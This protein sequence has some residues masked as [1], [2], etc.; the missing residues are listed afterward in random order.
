VTLARE[1][2]WAF[3][4][5]RR[6]V[7]AALVVRTGLFALTPA[8]IV[9]LLVAG[10]RHHRP[11]LRVPP[12][13][14]VVLLVG[15]SAWIA[16][17]ATGV[18]CARVA[19]ASPGRDAGEG[20]SE[21]LAVALVGGVYLLV[22]FGVL[23]WLRLA[24]AGA[25]TRYPLTGVV[26]PL[27]VATGCLLVL[28]VLVHLARSR[29][30]PVME[31]QATLR[32][33]GSAAVVAAVLAVAVVGLAGADRGDHPRLHVL[34]MGVRPGSLVAPL[35][36]TAVA[37]TIIRFDPRLADLDSCAD[38]VLDDGVDVVQ[39]P[40]IFLVVLGVALVPIIGVHHPVPA[41]ATVVALTVLIVRLTGRRVLPV[42][43]CGLAFVEYLLIAWPKGVFRHDAG[44]QAAAGALDRGGLFGSGPGQGLVEAYERGPVTLAGGPRTGTGMVADRYALNV[45]A[46][47]VGRIGVI[48]VLVTTVLIGLLVVRLA[49]RAGP[50]VRGAWA[51]GLAA[52]TVVTLA[53]PVVPLLWGDV[54]V[55]AALPG[56]APD[57]VSLVVLLG[58][59]AVLLGLAGGV[60]P[61]AETETWAAR[62]EARGSFPLGGAHDARAGRGAWGERRW[63]RFGPGLVAA[64]CVLL[65]LAAML[66]SPSAAAGAAPIAAADSQRA[67]M[68]GAPA[69][70]WPTL[71][72]VDPMV[73]Q[74]LDDQLRLRPRCGARLPRHAR[75]PGLGAAC[76]PVPAVTLDGQGQ[77]V[78]FRALQKSGYTGSVVA[79]DL[80]SGRLSVLAGDSSRTA[81][82]WSTAP[83]GILAKLLL[84]ATLNSDPTLAQAV[85]NDLRLAELTDHEPDLHAGD[86]GLVRRLRDS[87]QW[88]DPAF[89]SL[90]GK[91][92][93][94]IVKRYE[95]CVS[96]PG[97]RDDPPRFAT[98]GDCPL[99]VASAALA[100]RGR[101]NQPAATGKS[102]RPAVPRS[103]SALTALLTAKL[104]SAGAP[105]VAGRPV[106]GISAGDGEDCGG[107]DPCL[108]VSPLA[109]TSVVAALASLQDAGTPRALPAPR[110]LVDAGGPE[111]AS[112]AV[113]L[114]PPAFGTFG[115]KEA[116]PVADG[117]GGAWLIRLP[118]QGSGRQRT[119][120]VAHLQP[121][122]SPDDGGQRSDVNTAITRV[123]A[124]VADALRG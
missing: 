75:G 102:D 11:D 124:T 100:V 43:G 26:L 5:R 86:P 85:W 108:L 23:V 118:K 80:G 44:S 2:A 63:G 46:E 31:D 41:I 39:S 51:C 120:I 73:R 36:V 1:R 109:L 19:A 95:K 113:G 8:T 62:P 13:S 72:G 59:V 54:D 34:G 110:L 82:W 122:D 35:V 52:G 70:R 106:A 20:E 99:R 116:E 67:A 96:E 40:M 89:T 105:S 114:H 50:G 101:P 76:P 68:F 58:T 42:A 14:M 29:S 84:A 66:A 81:G 115:Q 6:P 111:P 92:D 77:R 28:P 4:D 25:G 64:G 83:M 45:L 69:L 56:V 74:A 94:Q 33:V 88:H 17:L 27:V 12:A 61:T 48:V 103:E 119:V 91:I 112:V 16:M 121:T 10:L 24:G 15:M 104:G 60:E 30:W 49:I 18:V 57:G 79:M 22:A 123:L 9:M 65:V 71:D 32:R 97:S 37:L 93:Q 98:E 21:R 3:T 55:E 47:E 38:E 117:V 90:I 107:V 87:E 78:A 53:L 7:S